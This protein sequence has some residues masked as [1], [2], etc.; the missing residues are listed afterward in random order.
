MVKDHGVNNDI[1]ELCAI[2]VFIVDVM[3]AYWITKVKELASAFTRLASRLWIDFSMNNFIFF[4]VHGLSSIVAFFSFLFL[5]SHCQPIFFFSSNRSMTLPLPSFSKIA[6]NQPRQP[7]MHLILGGC[8][9]EVLSS[10]QEACT[11]YTDSKAPRF[12]NC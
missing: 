10:R 2:R 9:V 4:F 3:L 8:L 5:Y 7:F 11:L 1:Y 6:C 12:I